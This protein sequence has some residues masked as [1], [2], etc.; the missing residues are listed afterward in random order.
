MADDTT[1]LERK[2]LA[3]EQIL[4]LRI[5]H[6]AETEP[7][8][9]DR[10]KAGFSPP[11]RPGSKQVDTVNSSQH[12]EQFIDGMGRKEVLYIK[13]PIIESNRTL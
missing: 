11:H 5:A 8:F 10:L 1:A 3:H 12:A 7:R 9:L 2:V 6:M 4:Q 13:Y